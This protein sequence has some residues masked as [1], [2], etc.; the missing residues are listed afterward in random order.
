MGE[1]PILVRPFCAYLLCRALFSV[2]AATGAL[3]DALLSFCR[4]SS[5]WK[6]VTAEQK[7]EPPPILSVCTVC[8]ALLCVSIM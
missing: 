4:G 1:P 5:F 7:F 8:R 3:V 2:C 6:K